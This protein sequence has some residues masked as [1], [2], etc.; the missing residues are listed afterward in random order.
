MPKVNSKNKTTPTPE[1]EKQQPAADSPK[2][3]EHPNPWEYPR[4]YGSLGTSD[5]GRMITL[6][7]GVTTLTARLVRVNHYIQSAP[8]EPGWIQSDEPL[9]PGTPCTGIVLDVLGHY[10]PFEIE[11]EDEVRLP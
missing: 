10:L 5:L 7:D 2:P 8:N 6:Q 3:Q 9:S 1:P 4:T 11:S